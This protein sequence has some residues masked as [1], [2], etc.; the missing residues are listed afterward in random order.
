M[1]KETIIRI[2]TKNLQAYEKTNNSWKKSSKQFP[3]AVQV[4]KLFK[5]HNKFNELI[6]KKNPI[7][8]KGQLYNNKC[9]GARINI[10]PN[11]QKIDK[12]YSLFAED[13]TIHDEA[14]H[15][16]WDIIYKN[17]NGKYAY[18]YTLKKKQKSS[19]E[20]YNHV[21]EFG[22]KYT[23]IQAHA[24]NELK[25]NKIMPLAIITLLKTN[26]R[27]GNEMFYK[28]HKSKGLTTLKKADMK[29]KGN[30]VTFKYLSKGLVPVE[31]QE[32]FPDLFIQKLR[33]HIKNLRNND[34]VFTGQD[35]K[36]LKDTDFE[37]TFKEYCGISF[38]P[39]IV[40]SYYAT[41]TIETFFKKNKHPDKKQLKELLLLVSEKLGHKK[42]NKKQ[43]CWQPSST[44]TISHYIA[45][46]LVEKIRNI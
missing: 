22:K 9:Q 40:R 21:K 36:P 45:P 16:H 43:N 17:P 46:K 18:C 33:N 39:H 7:F 27:V 34:F 5:A 14:S 12:A 1:K 31:T 25:T 20:K 24:Y 15:S 4:I 42:F 41:K 3:N 38:Y 44:V 32:Q 28:L 35:N 19:N 30:Q 11:S 10:L 6:D 37:K 26:M 8:L 29:I 13:L 23:Q 2:K